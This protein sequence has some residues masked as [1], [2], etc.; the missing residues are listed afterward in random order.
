MAFLDLVNQFLDDFT[1]MH[2]LRD[3]TIKSRPWCHLITFLSEN[4][5]SAIHDLL[6]VTRSQ[7]RLWGSGGDMANVSGGHPSYFYFGPPY[8]SD[9]ATC[10]DGCD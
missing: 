7:E 1:S 3:S 8:I 10:L 5:H 9:L 6:D 2:A 4:W